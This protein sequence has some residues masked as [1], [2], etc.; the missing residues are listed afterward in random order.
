[1]NGQAKIMSNASF[2]YEFLSQILHDALYDNLNCQ[3]YTIFLYFEEVITKA[4]CKLW[5]FFWTYVTLLSKN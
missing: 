4:T 1:M 5:C 2:T 3:L